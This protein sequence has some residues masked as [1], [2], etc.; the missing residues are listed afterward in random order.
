M[1]RL[2][3]TEHEP[4]YVFRRFRRKNRMARRDELYIGIID[5]FPP[6]EE[7]FLTRKLEREYD[8]IIMNRRSMA[9][10]IRTEEQDQEHYEK[11]LRQ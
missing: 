8:Y 1:R 10:Y 5:G 4:Y 3:T 2:N 7:V 6:R 11:R 9:Y